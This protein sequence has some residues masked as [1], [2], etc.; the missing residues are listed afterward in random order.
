MGVAA[1]SLVAGLNAMP[2]AA[3]STFKQLDLTRDVHSGGGR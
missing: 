1:T 3:L 2:S